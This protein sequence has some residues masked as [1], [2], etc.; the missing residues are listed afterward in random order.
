MA[1]AT[2]YRDD[3]L[4]KNTCNSRRGEKVEEKNPRKREEDLGDSL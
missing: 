4:G 3:L 1:T 2:D